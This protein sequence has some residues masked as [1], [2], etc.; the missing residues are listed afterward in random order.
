[1][2]I[3]THC[4]LNFPQYAA[5]LPAV[6]ARAADAGVGKYIVPAVDAEHAKSAVALAEEYDT[7]Y[8]AVGQHPGHADEFFPEGEAAFRALAQN[9]RVVAIGECGL[10]A[11]KSS[12]SAAVQEEV[13]RR[14]IALALEVGKPL[15]LHTRG[16]EARGAEILAEYPRIGGVA[17][18]YTAD[19]DTARRYIEL[20]FCIGITGII[21]YPGA[22]ALREVVRE[23]PLTSLL[24][25]TDGPYLAPQKYRG[26]QNE[27]AYVVEMA[28]MV[29]GLL[30]VSASEV[31]RVTTE[32][33]GRVFGV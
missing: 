27:P 29:A 16:A 12:A 19:L 31:G 15:I 4:H 20:G 13:F 18:C 32:N 9:A 21:T 14:H 24:L 33:A 5:D 8:A 3:D 22:S 11:V 26:M 1:M 17:H 7:I 10:D 23:L 6:L 25:E 2:L 28:E 30:G